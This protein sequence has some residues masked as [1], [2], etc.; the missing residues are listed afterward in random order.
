MGL[1]QDATS[2][3]VQKEVSLPLLGAQSQAPWGEDEAFSGLALGPFPSEVQISQVAV[4][5]MLPA[6]LS[7][8][9]WV[10]RKSGRKDLTLLNSLGSNLSRS[11]YPHTINMPFLA[12]I[13]L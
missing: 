7:L 12:N 8:G 10:A 5:W 9:V 1:L 3:L 4:S 2:Y 11:P 13:F 6:L